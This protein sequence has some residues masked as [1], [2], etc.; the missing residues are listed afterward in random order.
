MKRIYAPKHWLLDKLSGVW[1]PRPTP[2]PHK[3][4]ECVP[5][6]VLLRN[7]LKYALN[8]REVFMI[9]KDKAGHIRVDNK[10]RR[11]PHYPVGYN[12]VV[13]ID[14]SG[15]H[16][17]LLYDMKGRFVLHKINNDE[18]KYK[19]CKV[20]RH[21]TG[22]NSIPYILT[23]DGRTIRFPDPSIKASDTIKVIVWWI[24]K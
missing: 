2:G 15:D 14:K 22:S 6:M 23:H 19:L 4:R 10:T 21:G 1:A 20:L 13:S 5:L 16:F 11:D 18:A 7:K 24:I 3:L 8:Y 12:D 17:R 9:V